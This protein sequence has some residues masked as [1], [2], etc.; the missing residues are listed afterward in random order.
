MD[1]ALM[2]MYATCVQYCN[3]GHSAYQDIYYRPFHTSNIML[4]LV[5]RYASAGQ[6]TALI[7]HS[8]G[9]DAVVNGVAVKTRA[10]IDLLATLD[11]VSRKGAPGNKP[12][13]VGKFV[14]V[15]IGYSRA[16]LTDA[17]N[18]LARVGKP[19]QR[20]P[21]ADE[22]HDILGDAGVDAEGNRFCHADA[23][24]MFWRYAAGHVA[25]LR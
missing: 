18:T 3:A 16:A 19:W 20:V 11:P 14:N 1:E 10:A 7:G 5:E 2:H 25:A 12:S 15:Y 6:K 21:Y 8:W 13:N 22:N 9:G 24:A 23:S 4:E 17:S